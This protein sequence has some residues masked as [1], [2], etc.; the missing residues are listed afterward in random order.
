MDSIDNVVLFKRAQRH[1]NQVEDLAKNRLKFWDEIAPEFAD[2]FDQRWPFLD[3]IVGTRKSPYMAGFP[4]SSWAYVDVDFKVEAEP[5]PMSEGRL[6]QGTFEVESRVRRLLVPEFGE[7]TSTTFVRLLAINEPTHPKRSETPNDLLEQ[8][9]AYTMSFG[10]CDNSNKMQFGLAMLAALI[11]RRELQF[12]SVEIEDSWF[13]VK[14]YDRSRTSLYR[15]SF[16]FLPIILDDLAI[17]YFKTLP[18]D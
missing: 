17:K 5:D 12:V 14:F 3:V 6:Y 16:S 18:D 9:V 11:D 13:V 8:F 7:Q 2:G 1:K 15:F 10:E 4:E